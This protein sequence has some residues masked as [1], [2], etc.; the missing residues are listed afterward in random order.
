[1]PSDSKLLFMNRQ[2]LT[3]KVLLSVDSWTSRSHLIV[4]RRQPRIEC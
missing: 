3:E 4:P 1:L 2:A